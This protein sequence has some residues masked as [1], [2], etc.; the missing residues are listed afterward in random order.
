MYFYHTD[1]G[2]SL[3]WINR[4]HDDASASL[5]PFVALDG[6]GIKGF[7]GRRGWC[8]GDQWIRLVGIIVNST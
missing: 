1:R 5:R 3:M 7:F 2:S 6:N 8:L 4:S